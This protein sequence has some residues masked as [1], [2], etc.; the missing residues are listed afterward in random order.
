MHSWP[1]RPHLDYGDIIHDKPDNE[2]FKSKIEN[3]QYK[4]CTAITSAIQATSR[5]RLYQELGLESSENRRWY[6]KLL[7]FH[8]TVNGATPRYLT[9]YLNTNENPVFTTRAS[10][11][12]KIRR[13][14][15]R[16]EHFKQSFFPI[17]VNEWYKLDSSLREAKSIKHIY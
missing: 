10:N 8:K 13:F 11:Q 2:S 6:R 1:I 12:N 4:A 3:I 17:C 5:E 15:A 7:F 16:T 14:R 9:S